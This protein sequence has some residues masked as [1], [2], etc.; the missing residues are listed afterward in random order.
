MCQRWISVCDHFVYIQH[1][2]RVFVCQSEG[3]SVS[4]AEEDI[5]TWRK[6]SQHCRLLDEAHSKREA[7]ASHSDLLFISFVDK[8][9][10]EDFPHQEESAPGPTC[11]S[12]RLVNDTFPVFT[13]SSGSWRADQFWCFVSGREKLNKRSFNHFCVFIKR[14]CYFSKFAFRS[15]TFTFDLVKHIP[16]ICN[17]CM[18]QQTGNIWGQRS[19]GDNTYCSLQYCIRGRELSR[20]S[21]LKYSFRNTHKT[22][23][24]QKWRRRIK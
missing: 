24:N 18:Q 2:T 15:N 1:L 4:P 12:H 21:T 11:C 22:Q 5:I 13:G 19:L 16:S 7:E 6:R 14:F 23:I 20:A 17:T 8:I 3:S 10:P 9:Q